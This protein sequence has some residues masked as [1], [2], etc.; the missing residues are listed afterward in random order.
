MADESASLQVRAY[1]RIRQSII[2]AELKPGE[3]LVVKDLC[4][5]LGMGRTPVRESLVRLQFGGLVRAVPQSGT[6]V[7]RVDLHSAE[8]ARFAREHL[9]QQA[10]IECCARA[11]EDDIEMLDRII[12]LQ[13][14]AVTERDEPN[15]FTTDNLLHRTIFDIAGRREVWNWLDLTNTHLERF[16]W[17]SAITKGIDWSV[18]MDHHYAIRNAIAARKTGEVSYLVAMHAHKMLADKDKVVAAH[19]DYFDIEDE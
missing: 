4:D 18:I 19:P 9:E 1:E 11:S 7:S 5:A 10:A 6:Y 14:Q 17:L 3:R 2:L 13:R 8:N 12:D 15:F 16:R